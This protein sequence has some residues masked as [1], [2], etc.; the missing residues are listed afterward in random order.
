MM[1]IDT[2]VVKQ[3]NLALGHG[4]LGQ[5]AQFKQS[6]FSFVL[7]EIVVREVRR[8]IAESIRTD[9]AAWPRIARR[10]ERIP[11]AADE[12]AALAAALADVSPEQIAYREVEQFL[13]ATGAEVIT[14]D[15][16]E[17]DR[18]LDLY[19]D[20]KPPFGTGGKRHE[21]PDAIALLGI[22][23]WCTA[24]NSGIIVVSSDADWMRF[25]AASAAGRFHVVDNLATALDI[26][27]STAAERD[28][29]ARERQE[30]LVEKLRDGQLSREVQN[31][32][33]RLL[34]EQARARGTSRS[35]AYLADIVRVE[36]GDVSYANPGRIR[37]DDSAFA[38]LV[39]VR[40]HCTFWA[41]FNFYNPEMTQ[42][43]GRG[44]YGAGQ[45]VDAAA[46]ITVERGTVSIE[47]LFKKEELVIDFGEVEPDEDGAESHSPI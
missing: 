9:L 3:N 19:F 18:V 37:D 28:V 12:A 4:L 36:V 41:N 42:P 33:P 44:V 11:E 46:I 32:L 39:D 6:R 43:M 24:A 21:F 16:V 10:L 2:S 25:C 14:A 31:Q 8:Q 47:V 27:N 5:L 26:V 35:L 20:G 15:H 23:A 7:S 1:T 29:R 13:I 34:L 17:L 40:A 22:D 38:V 30:R 45:D